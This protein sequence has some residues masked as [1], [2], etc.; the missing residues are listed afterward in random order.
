MTTVSTPPKDAI[1]VYQ[2]HARQWDLLEA[3]ETYHPN[4]VLYGGQAGGGKSHLIRA[5]AYHYANKWPGSHIAIFRRVY[6]ELEKTHVRAFMQEL[7]EH[8]Y[9]FSRSRYQIELPNGSMIEFNHAATFDDVFNYQSVEWAMCMIDEVEQFEEEE[10]DELKSRVRAPTDG[11]EADWEDWFPCLFLTAN[12]GG[13]GHSYLKETFVNPGVQANLN[14]DKPYWEELVEIPND[15]DPIAIR[16][17]YVPAALKDNPSLNRRQYSATLASLSEARRK[18]L[19]E[20]DWDYFAGKA[21]E[22]LNAD[23][24]LVDPRRL[25]GQTESGSMRPR[26]VDWP[27][28]IGLDHGQVAPTC[29][30]WTVEDPDGFFLTYL[31]YYK[32]NTAVGTHIENVKTYL[33]RDQSQAVVPYADPNMWRVNRGKGHMVWSLADEYAW[34]GDPPEDRTGTPDG[35]VLAH[36]MQDREVRL[37][38]LQRIYTPQEDRMFPVWHPKAGQ[39]GSPQAFIA[40]HCINYWRELNLARLKDTADERGFQDIEKMDDH[41]IDAA[42]FSVPMLERR[43]IRRSTGPRRVL[44]PSTKRKRP[45]RAARSHL[46]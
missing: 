40:S 10:I 41:S 17:M 12:P 16:R 24:H 21:F 4:E 14:P 1:P 32:P 44:K 33:Q 20:G 8:E 2:L 28:V 46:L 25:F 18:Q 19:L 5:I 31:E 27:V 3:L 7:P 42:G 6:A 29:A 15:P 22:M 37:T 35:I 26:P 13:K 9:N 39:Y 23:T 36:G 30:L 38:T 43:T 11:Q 34:N 45:T